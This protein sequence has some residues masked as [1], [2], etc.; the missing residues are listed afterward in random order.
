MP[1]PGLPNVT[2]TVTSKQWEDRRADIERLYVVKGYPLRVVR[3]KLAKKD[4]QPR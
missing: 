2:A 4:F 1:I 3:E